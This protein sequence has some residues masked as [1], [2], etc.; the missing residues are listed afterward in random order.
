MV[1]FSRCKYTLE[2]YNIKW[3]AQL[4]EDSYIMAPLWGLRETLVL[5]KK[6]HCYM[7]CLY[8]KNRSGIGGMAPNKPRLCMKL[9]RHIHVCTKEFI[10]E[11]LQFH[12][13]KQSHKHFQHFYSSCILWANG[14]FLHDANRIKVGCMRAHSSVIPQWRRYDATDVTTAQSRKIDVT[15]AQSRKIDVTTACK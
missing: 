12:K 6:V 5:Q 13:G 9:R 10:R 3:R 7:Q 1:H 8:C 11:H 15:T 14:L 2:V 4:L